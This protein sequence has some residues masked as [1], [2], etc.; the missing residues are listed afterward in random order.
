MLCPGT[1]SLMLFVSDNNEQIVYE[2]EEIKTETDTEICTK[3]NLDSCLSDA[4]L[5]KACT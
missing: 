5:L 3:Y 4:R 2:I 1:K